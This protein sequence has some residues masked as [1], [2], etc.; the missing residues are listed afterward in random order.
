MKKINKIMIVFLIFNGFLY[1]FG[2]KEEAPKMEATMEMSMDSELAVPPPGFATEEYKKPSE[3]KLLEELTKLQFQVTQKNGTETPFQNSYW[4]NHKEGIYV[5]IVS[6]EVLFSSI[7]K[8]DSRTGWPS[9]TRPLEAGN[10]IELRDSSYGMVRIEVRSLYGDSHLGHLFNDGPKPEG[11]R[12][13][14]NSASLR[15]IA[16]SDLEKEGYGSYL[17]LFNKQ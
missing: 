9:F 2:K 13:C 4:D 1:S 17:P 3:K 6:G 14:I 7:D 16:V 5:D 15:F 11:L 8:Y 12:Y 10:I